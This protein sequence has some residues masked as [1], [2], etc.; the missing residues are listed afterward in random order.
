MSKKRLTREEVYKLIDGERDYQEK[1]SKK[2][3]H[4]GIPTAE[5]EILM[6][7]EYMAKVRT[8]WV[9]HYDEETSL[10]MIRK[11]V[12]MGVRCLENYGSEKCARKL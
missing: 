12:G 1:Q 7:E 6:M 4:Q 10:D 9:N 11:V 8:A 3:D 2:W 5:A